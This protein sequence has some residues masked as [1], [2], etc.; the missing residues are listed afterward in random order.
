MFIPSEG[1]P[2]AAFS[3]KIGVPNDWWSEI[4]RKYQIFIVVVL[5]LV[6][7]HMSINHM[8]CR[9]NSFGCWVE[10]RLNVFEKREERDGRD[11]FYIKAILSE[12]EARKQGQ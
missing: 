7:G 2:F 4:E 12:W 6:K 11:W 1:F 8:A 3:H 9:P 10:Q 5:F